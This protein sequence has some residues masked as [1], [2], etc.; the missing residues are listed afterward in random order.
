MLDSGFETSVQN[1]A[2]PAGGPPPVPR[3][4]LP[5]WPCR[6]FAVVLVPQGLVALSLSLGRAPRV[7]CCALQGAPAGSQVTTEPP[8]LLTWPSPHPCLSVLRWGVCLEGLPGV[9]VEASKA[10]I[11]LLLLGCALGSVSSR[12]SRGFIPLPGGPMVVGGGLGAIL[13][14]PPSC[15]LPCAGKSLVFTPGLGASSVFSE[16]DETA[17]SASGR[18]WDVAVFLQ[19]QSWVGSGA[20][21]PAGPRDHTPPAGSALP[22]LRFLHQRGQVVC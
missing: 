10:H 19:W 1:G 18:R 6:L 12:G 11:L 7:P 13:Q 3:G 21:L 5:G 8:T 16:T 20:G 15:G 14:T 4:R 17:R 9:G 2:A 22:K